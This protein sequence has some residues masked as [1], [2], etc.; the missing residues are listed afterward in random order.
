MRSRSRPLRACSPLDLDSTDRPRALGSP[1][2]RRSPHGCGRVGR[3]SPPDAA[4]FGR[5][6]PPARSGLHFARAGPTGP[7]PGWARD[8]CEPSVE[9]FGA[10]RAAAD[11]RETRRHRSPR[12]PPWSAAKATLLSLPPS[13]PTPTHPRQVPRVRR[14]HRER[15]T[16]SDSAR[17]RVRARLHGREGLGDAS[18]FDVRRRLRGAHR[19]SRPDVHQE[20]DRE[21]KM[22]SAHH[23]NSRGGASDFRRSARGAGDQSAAERVDPFGDRGDGSGPATP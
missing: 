13:P 10:H 5:P 2:Q 17:A 22:S 20:Q 3:D 21:S 4:T 1:I 14:V 15:H 18:A 8:G 12:H 11:R 6:R 7:N 16:T 9:E 19:S 23:E